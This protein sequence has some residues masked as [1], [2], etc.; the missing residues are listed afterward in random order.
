M[1]VKM[2]SPNTILLAFLVLVLSLSHGSWSGLARSVVSDDFM[3]SQSKREL[4]EQSNQVAS[5]PVKPGGML[6]LEPLQESDNEHE[7]LEVVPASASTA[8]LVDGDQSIACRG[9]YRVPNCRPNCRGGIPYPRC[10]P[11]SCPP[12]FPGCIPNNNPCPVQFFP[13]QPSP[14]CQPTCT[15]NTTPCYQPE[16]SQ[17]CQPSSTPCLG[18]AYPPQ[19]GTN[20]PGCVNPGCAYPPQSGSDYPPQPWCGNPGCAY[21]PPQS[22]SDYPPS[23]P[24]CVN[25]GCAYPPQSGPDYPPQCANPGCAYPP[26]SGSAYPP[27]SNPGCLSPDCQPTNQ[28]PFCAFPGCQ[29][30]DLFYPPQNEASPGTGPRIDEQNSL[31]QE[32]NGSLQPNEKVEIDEVEEGETMSKQE[33]SG[34]MTPSTI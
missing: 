33:L 13:P 19:S 22:G 16:P 10:Y 9:R 3:L 11:N 29:P 27:Q 15:P 7:P 26:Q 20:Y 25:S 23:N 32:S 24:G 14:G 2:A 5:E 12:N 18:C 8:S 34:F 4:S 21:S 1:Q 30:P 17:G 31:E 28:P 6:D